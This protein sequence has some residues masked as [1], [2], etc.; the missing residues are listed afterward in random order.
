MNVTGIMEQILDELKAIRQTLAAAGLRPPL[1]GQAGPDTV[2]IPVPADPVQQPSAQ[3]IPMVQPN[4]GGLMDLGST[5]PPT[6]PE[7]VVTDA[8]VTDLI[9]PHLANPALKAAFQ[10]VIKQMGIE[11]LP[12]AKPEQY[13]ELFQRFTAVIQQSGQAAQPA[14][15]LSII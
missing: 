12:E 4:A 11:R 5:L 13:A 9:Q 10:G 3:V 15:T 14:A 7:K 2:P 6:L 1:I 8:D